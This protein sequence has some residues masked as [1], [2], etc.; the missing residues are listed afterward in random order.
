MAPISVSLQNLCLIYII[1]F[2]KLFPV[3]YLALLPVTVRQRLLENLPPADV[4]RL[5]QSKFSEGL[6]IDGVWKKLSKIIHI[7]TLYTRCSNPP[8]SYL[9]KSYKDSFFHQIYSFPATKRFETSLTEHRYKIVQC[10]CT[11]LKPQKRSQLFHRTLTPAANEHGHKL[12]QYFR[13]EQLYHI[14]V[15]PRW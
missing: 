9:S 14:L 10:L 1:R 5:E 4:C 7:V 6:D 11:P 13:L 8:A 2:L 15:S 12:E 3:D